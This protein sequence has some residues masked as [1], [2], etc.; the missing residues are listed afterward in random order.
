MFERDNL[1]IRTEVCAALEVFERGY[2]QYSKRLKF[3]SAMTQRTPS[4]KHVQTCRR[5]NVGNRKENFKCARGNPT[6]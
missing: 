5:G 2:D 1:G 6:E 3:V 4:E